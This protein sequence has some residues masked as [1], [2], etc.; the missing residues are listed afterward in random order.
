MAGTWVSLPDLCTDGFAHAHQECLDWADQGSW[1][2]T[3]WADE[4]ANECSEWADEGHK[5]CCDWWP[6]SWACDAWYWVAKW[7]CKAWYWVAKWVCL[8][9]IWVAN[10]A[11]TFWTWVISWFCLSKANGGALF[12]L[13]DGTVLMNE[14]GYAYGTRRWWKLTPDSNGSYAAGSWSRV[15]DSK[16]ARLYFASAVLADGRLLVCGGEY[17]DATGGQTGDDTAR[18]EI[19]DPV[20]D[21]WTDVAPPAGWTM[22]GDASCALLPDG[23]FL[24]GNTLDKL[25]SI[26]DP[27]AGT[28]SADI[29]KSNG[30]KEES[31]VLMPDNT[32]IA[33]SCVGHPASGKF[34]V[35]TETW[36]A[37]GNL[38]ADIV[39]NASKEVGPGFLLPD[40]RAFFV[41]ATGS[42]ALYTMAQPNTSQGTWTA[43]PG[44]PPAGTQTL[45]S[46]DGPGCVM[47]NGHVLF[48][49][50]PVN[51]K[52]DDYLSPCTFFE[53]DGTNIVSS[54]DAPNSDCV[55]YQGRLLM[56]PTGEIMWA[57]NNDTAFYAFQS[58]DQPQD[59][60]RPVITN[61]PSQVQPG[62]TIM[63]S[64][65]QF[66]GLSQTVGYG[67]DYSA[68]TNYPL[69]RIR[70]KATG[71][72][73]YC[74][75]SNHTT[76]DGN[77]AAVTSMGVATG[78]AVITTT[79]DV[80]SDVQA[81]DSELFVVANGIPSSPFDV[82]VSTT[83]TETRGRHP[84]HPA[85]ETQ[86]HRDL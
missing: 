21:T 61:C 22:I 49:A 85:T 56:L 57:R 19:Y 60:W 78:A 7:V 26:F 4:G 20:A 40:G 81:G 27:V 29:S 17:S 9:A 59:Q 13:T 10:W 84:R 69:V 74:R 18:S 77:G 58:R 50:A 63:I 1:A 71:H 51:G 70:N 80:P 36:Q 82:V 11:C 55:T 24:M 31:W 62:S 66:N 68:A 3:Q 34:I 45:G 8:A 46:K 32:V 65:L 37:E 5:N 75:T 33:P 28:W 53:F 73:R 30:S 38:A 25:T 76:I 64:G 52:R 14:C 41:G 44:I 67:D 35:T 86:R 47:V 83:A 43:G 15:A 72:V 54:T 2:C 16:V 79:V 6:C 48:P 42:T 39:E 23:R 12:L